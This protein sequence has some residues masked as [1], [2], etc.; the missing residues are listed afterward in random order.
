MQSGERNTK[1]K[2]GKQE[3]E[4]ELIRVSDD[5][6]C[7]RGKHYFEYKSSR[8]VK[9][10]KCPVGYPIGVGITLKDGHIYKDCILVI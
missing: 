9:C 3:D 5:I 7:R 6:V 2:L 1:P 8:E 10:K 4:S